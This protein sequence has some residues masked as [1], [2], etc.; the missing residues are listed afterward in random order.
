MSYLCR[1]NSCVDICNGKMYILSL[2]TAIFF[3]V[4]VGPAFDGKSFFFASFFVMCHISKHFFFSQYNNSLLNIS[5]HKSFSFT[6]RFHGK[7]NSFLIPHCLLAEFDSSSYVKF[8]YD[9]G[10]HRIW[11]VFVTDNSPHA[12]ALSFVPRIFVRFLYKFSVDAKLRLRI[13]TPL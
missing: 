10:H 9:F 13:A 5:I 8:E 11:Y 4:S 1:R 7:K 2:Y 12:R 3:F 6:K